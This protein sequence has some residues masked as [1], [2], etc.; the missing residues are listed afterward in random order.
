MAFESLKLR[1]D[2]T[3]PENI[4]LNHG[5]KAVQETTANAVLRIP[6]D[7]AKE[8]GLKPRLYTKLS[9]EILHHL[10]ICTPE[11]SHSFMPFCH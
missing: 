1:I 8:R 5:R 4:F 10:W 11:D 2:V 9:N 7:Y 3:L 6:S